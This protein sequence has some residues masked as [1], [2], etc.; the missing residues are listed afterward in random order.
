MMRGISAPIALIGLHW[1]MKS[2][3]RSPVVV[4]SAM[5]AEQR[6]Q[7]ERAVNNSFTFCLDR[8]TSHGVFLIVNDDSICMYPLK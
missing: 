5:S 6:E 4:S 8:D 2:D 1:T 3:T 7:M